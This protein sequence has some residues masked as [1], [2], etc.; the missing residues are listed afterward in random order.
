MQIFVKVTDANTITLDV[1]ASDTI[2]AVKAKIQ[3][4]AGISPDQQ[5]LIYCGEQLFDSLTVNSAALEPGAQ[6]EL[7]RI[8][9]TR[10]KWRLRNRRL[11]APQQLLAQLQTPLSEARSH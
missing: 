9:P 10:A 8:R 7:V 5:H 1:E 6:L 4:M 3:D 2:G 11:E